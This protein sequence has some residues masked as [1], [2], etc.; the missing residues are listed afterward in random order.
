MSS[1][2]SASLS[3]FTWYVPLS[4]V[5]LFLQNPP[6]HPFSTSETFT[7]LSKCM[8]LKDHLLKAASPLSLELGKVSCRKEDPFL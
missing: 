5:F 1:D 7:H 6:L 3:Y 2:V 8:Q 4:L